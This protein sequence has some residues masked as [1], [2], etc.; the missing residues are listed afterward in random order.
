M[1]IQGPDNDSWMSR[2]VY[3]DNLVR[4][5]KDFSGK[6]VPNIAEKVETRGDGREYTFHLRGGM[7]WSDGKPFT[8][9]D[10]TFALE[11][12]LLDADISPVPP[13]WLVLKEDDRP[14][15]D[16][17]DDT[18]LRL[19]YQHPNGMLLQRIATMSGGDLTKYARHYFKRFHKKYNKDVAELAK[20]NG[21]NDWTKFFLEQADNH[22]NAD[23][24]TLLPWKLTLGVEKGTRVT[25]ER[26]PYYWKTD[27]QGRQLPYVD[28]LIFNIISDPEVMLLKAGGGE[29]DMYCTLINTL[30]NKPVLARNR[31]KGEFHFFDVNP[32]LMNGMMIALNLCHPDPAL[33][34]VFQN[35]DFRIGLSHAINRRELIDSVA[36]GQGKP[37]QG[38]PR[39]ESPFYDERLAK[40]YIEYDVDRAKA[41]L[42]RAGYRDTDAEGFRLRPDGKRIRI[43]VEVS[44][45]E[46]FWVDAMQ[47]VKGYWAKVGVDSHVKTE[48]R[49]LFYERKDANTH[50]AGVWDG[51]G[52]LYDG[53]LD[54]RWYM[55]YSDES[56]Y[57][58]PWAAWFNSRGAEGQQPPPAARRQMSLYRKMEGTADRREQDRLFGEILRIAREQF[59]AIGTFL[60]TQGYGI[61]ANDFHNVP[62][63][64]IWSWQYPSPGV[65]EPE[66]YFFEG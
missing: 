32:A 52:G 59:W 5:T 44:P 31:K 61:V 29:I 30:R 26:N 6:V 9:A 53:L 34:K 58:T 42:D 49:G 14:T 8:A 35:K 50:D 15:V 3:Y 51:D 40:Q 12:V 22:N 39:E 46:D 48:A 38:A 43:V 54:P 37:W 10:L 63:P 41:H 56:I 7:R 60:P 47:L 4:W 13:T 28:H 21:H 23:A 64:L 18:T 2:S 66:Q 11:D 1:A 24:P 62:D 65:T 20:S 45:F 25:F 27:P 17:P 55:P 33:R 19:R 57:A 16:A 36:Q